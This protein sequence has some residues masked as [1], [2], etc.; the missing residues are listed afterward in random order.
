MNENC[1]YFLIPT[2]NEGDVTKLVLGIKSDTKELNNYQIDVRLIDDGSSISTTCNVESTP[3]F[4]VRV[5]KLAVNLGPG[6]AFANG[7]RTLPSNLSDQDIVILLEG[8][9][10]SDLKLI[11]K[12]INRLNEMPDGY[13]LVLASPYTFGG[14]LKSISLFRRILS[15]IANES[16]RLIL[17]LRGLWTLSSFFRVARGSSINKLQR[18]YGEEIILSNGFECMVEFLVK[19]K[20]LDFTISEVASTVDQNNRAGR[21]RMKIF[22]TIFGYLKVWNIAKKL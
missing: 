4:S 9:G 13:D 15:S 8:D 18:M 11:P 3:N 21:S 16:S 7:F 6:G 14:N 2:F 5:D 12:M 10:T 22:K 19:C 17:D 1:I 20:S